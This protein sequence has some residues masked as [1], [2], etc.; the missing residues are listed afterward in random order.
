MEFSIYKRDK[1]LLW[2][3]QVPIEIFSGCTSVFLEQGHSYSGR[4]LLD[5]WN[6]FCKYVTIYY[7]PTVDSALDTEI[8]NDDVTG[9]IDVLEKGW[10]IEVSEKVLVQE[11]I[12][13]H[14]NTVFQVFVLNK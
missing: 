1:D 2:C 5:I 9:G 8:S 11:N 13:Q 12:T 4:V 7:G 6:Q 14:W 3:W 10:Y